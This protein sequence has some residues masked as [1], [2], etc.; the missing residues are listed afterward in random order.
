MQLEQGFVQFSAAAKSDDELTRRE[1]V[2]KQVHREYI[3]V[4]VIYIYIYI[5]MYMHV[6]TDEYIHVYA[7]MHL[8]MYMYTHTHI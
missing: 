4:C 1:E 3:R 6:Y 5:Y 7:C 8:C 2:I